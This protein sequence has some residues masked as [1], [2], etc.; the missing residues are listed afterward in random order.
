[1]VRHRSQVRARAAVRAVVPPVLWEGLR[2]LAG[3]PAVSQFT[4]QGVSTVHD[5]RPLHCGAFREA[6]DRFATLD[7]R[8]APDLTRLRTYS[9]WMFAHLAA[10]L[11]GAFLFG[12]V[13]YGVAPR[14]VFELLSNTAPGRAYYLVDPFRGTDGAMQV[15]ATYNTDAELVRRQYP[16]GANVRMVEEYLP[17]CLP[18]EG[19][20]AIAFAQLNTGHPQAEV[21]SLPYLYDRLLPGGVLLIDSYA[22]LAGT[23]RPAYDTALATLGATAFTLVTGQGVVFK[24]LG[25]E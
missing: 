16:P 5:M 14:V 12:G 2:R 13:S 22:F 21:D 20:P 3:R 23:S 10:P 9:A 11:P 8:I 25:R 6:F 1:M 24:P 4:Y 7:Q 15:R 19:D 18:L 17:A